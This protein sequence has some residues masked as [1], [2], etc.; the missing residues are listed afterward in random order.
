MGILGPS[1][2]IG[3]LSYL[4]NQDDEQNI[5]VVRKVGTY[6]KGRFIYAD[7]ISLE[8]KGSL[9]PLTAREILQLSEGDRVKSH[10]KFYSTFKMTLDDF[11]IIDGKSYEIQRVEDWD[12]YTKSVAVLEDV[13]APAVG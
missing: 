7:P 13:N 3:K 8:V 10:F 12:S 9:Q 11:L 4:V 1:N 5:S 6:V 2:E